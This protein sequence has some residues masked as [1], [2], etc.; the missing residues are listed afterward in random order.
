MSSFFSYSKST[1]VSDLIGGH[2]HYC[3]Y[4]VYHNNGQYDTITRE[5]ETDL[6]ILSRKVQINYTSITECN[7]AGSKFN[8]PGLMCGELCVEHRQW[9]QEGMGGFCGKYN[10]SMTNKQLC[11]NTTFW[12][13]KTCDS[14]FKGGE[15]A[16]LGRRCTG[17]T[18]H[19]SY[20]WY[21]SNIYSYEVNISLKNNK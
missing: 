9:C 19:C 3:D 4:N 1:L 2:H 11:A 16:A 12:S 14:F 7:T 8:L 6:N 5:D 10:F 15:K 18:Q 13:G 20:P 17:A 21:T